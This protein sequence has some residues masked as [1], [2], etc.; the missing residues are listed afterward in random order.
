MNSSKTTAKIWLTNEHVQERFK[1][2]L[3]ALHKQTLNCTKIVR[4]SVSMNTEKILK[5]QVHV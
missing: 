4:H 5:R 2:N 1:V 3:E